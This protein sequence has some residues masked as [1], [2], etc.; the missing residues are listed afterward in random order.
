MDAIA[1]SETGLRSVV[2]SL[3]EGPEAIQ[4]LP[5]R[6]LKSQASAER[7]GGKSANLI[8]LSEIFR[9]RRK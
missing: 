4:V 1:E 8:D 6:Q 7:V 5:R 9:A 3:L 2:R